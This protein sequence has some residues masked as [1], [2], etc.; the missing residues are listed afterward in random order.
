MVNLATIDIT[1]ITIAVLIEPPAQPKPISQKD[2]EQ[3]LTRPLA[4]GQ[5]ADGLILSS[6]RDQTEVITSG[7]KINVRDLSGRKVFSDSKIPTV[8]N[9]F[10]A[11]TSPRITSYGVNFI[12]VVPCVEPLQWIRDN[13]LSP[14]I[15][16]RTGMRLLG[17]AGTLKIASKSKTWNIK[18]EPGDG[19]KINLDFNASEQTQ[20][21]PDEGRLREELQEQFDA[22]LQLL[23]DLGL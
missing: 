4:I 1:M 14:Q 11:A 3:V 21:L 5:L 12:V 17:G 18:F 16:E 13:I 20:Q 22:F 6:Q 9:F 8:L 23:N 19:D 7:N 2:L 10:L 15:F